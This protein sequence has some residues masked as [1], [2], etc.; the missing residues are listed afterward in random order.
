MGSVHMFGREESRQMGI[1]IYMRWD[2]M[3]EEEKD[4]R[5]TGF[6]IASGHTGY[7]REA[8]HGEPYATRELVPE[9]FAS[10]AP[11]EGAS[12]P[13]KVLRGRLP[14]TLQLHIKRQWDVYKEDVNWESPSA[15]SFTAFV[16]LAERMETAGKNPTI[17]ASY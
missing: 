16:E 5:Y 6:D 7:L 9:A 1:D 4:A 8:Y 15:E 3:T 13:C 17:V 14:K 11:E 12:I 10:D 2:N